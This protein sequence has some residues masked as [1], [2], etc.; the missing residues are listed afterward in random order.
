MKF[1]EILEQSGYYIVV[2]DLPGFWKTE[3]HEVFTLE[4]YASIIEDF[5]KSL[6]LGSVTILWHSNG[7]AIATII[8]S[9]G[10]IN[11]KKMVLNNSAGIRRDKKRGFKRRVLSSL[12]FM[13][14]I[15]GFK[16]LRPYFHRAIWAQDYAAAEKTPYLSESYQNMIQSDLQEVYPKLDNEVLLIWGER[17]SYTPLPDGKR[18]ESLLRNAKMVVLDG[19]KH[20]IHLQNPKRL[21]KVLIKNV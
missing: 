16:V 3:I 21:G 9:R 8:A 15:P 1:S 4:K 14:H 6:G 18:I 2:P 19:E 10:N 13:K 20:G 17:D 11:L 5:S 7:W 12:L